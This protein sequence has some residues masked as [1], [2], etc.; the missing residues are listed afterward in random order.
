MD[1]RRRIAEV[2][3][4]RPNL[5][6]VLVLDRVRVTKT[7][8]DVHEGTVYGVWGSRG[9]RWL[10]VSAEPIESIRINEDD[11]ETIERVSR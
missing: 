11:I 2:K 1:T 8:G 5:D 6:G 3:A 10:V 7:S 9:D 4:A